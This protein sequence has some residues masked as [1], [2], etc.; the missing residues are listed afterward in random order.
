MIH[1]DYG[2]GNYMID[3]DTGQITVYDFDDSCFCWYMYD[4]ADLWKSG[5]GWVQ[6]EQDTDKRKKFMG[7]YFQ[8]ALE[9]YKSETMLED[10]MLER[11]PLFINVTIMENIMSKFE[12]MRNNGEEPECDEELSYRIKCLEDDIPYIGFFHEIYS[13][14][15]P[16]EYLRPHI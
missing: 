7:E 12:Q 16:F 3:F 5:T 11:L 2:D 15:A 13:C 8:T 6:F 1:F 14:K 9:G 10:S 4:L